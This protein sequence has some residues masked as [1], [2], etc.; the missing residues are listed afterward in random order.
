MA[1]IQKSL[2]KSET[3]NYGIRN[4]IKKFWYM[5]GIQAKKSRTKSYTNLFFCRDLAVWDDAAECNKGLCP[6]LG[7]NS[8][9]CVPVEW[10][11]T[12]GNG[13]CPHAANRGTGMSYRAPG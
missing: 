4:A 8:C 10:Y 6:P 11:C 7:H 2:K 3:K 5:S 12:C 13:S 9:M 1:G